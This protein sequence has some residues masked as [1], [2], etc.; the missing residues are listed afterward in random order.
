LWQRFKR[1]EKLPAKERGQILQLID[2]FF[3]REKLRRNRA[4]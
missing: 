1:V 2:A 3:E 4:G